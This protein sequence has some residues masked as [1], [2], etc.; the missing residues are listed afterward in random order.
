MTFQSCTNLRAF[1]SNTVV[2]IQEDLAIQFQIYCYKNWIYTHKLR[3][4][5]PKWIVGCIYK[6]T[7]KQ[8][9]LI[10]HRYYEIL[11]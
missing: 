1:G 3:L 10:V 11:S 6:S 7:K 8:L 5:G 2:L 9:T 4:A